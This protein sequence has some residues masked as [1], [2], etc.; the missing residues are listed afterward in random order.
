ME[1][2]TTT[3]KKIS[4]QPGTIP[5]FTPKPSPLPI[6]PKSPDVKMQYKDTG[7]IRDAPSFIPAGEPINFS[8]IKNVFNV[9]LIQN[10]DGR[11]T[12]YFIEAYFGQKILVS[13]DEY[14]YLYGNNNRSIN[15]KFINLYNAEH[16]IPASI[17]NKDYLVY[18]DLHNVLPTL[19]VINDFRSNINIDIIDNNIQNDTALTQLCFNSTEQFVNSNT[20]RC[21][22]ENVKNNT[23]IHIDSTNSNKLFSKSNS[24]FKDT[25]YISIACD[26]GKC[27]FEPAD[28][29]YRGLIART[30]LYFDW[31]YGGIVN[32]DL[33]DYYHITK[34]EM[35]SRSKVNKEWYSSVVTPALRNLMI[36]WDSMYPPTEYEINRHT[37]IYNNKKVI[38]PFT[39]EA[40]KC[41]NRIKF[42]PIN[43]TFG[44]GN[45]SNEECTIL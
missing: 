12:W 34:F 32:Y 40:I 4:I 3:L 27:K 16:I 24:K 23:C 29:V 15:E 38:N 39:L 8:L 25:R 41:N 20:I 45:V 1:S 35:D 9:S 33:P 14:N 30:I 18:T 22:C 17:Y 43:Q 11:G 28:T 7:V 31:K 2:T 6:N 37:N 21:P 5:T 10:K 13:S 42:T 36:K 26:F 44:A 19:T